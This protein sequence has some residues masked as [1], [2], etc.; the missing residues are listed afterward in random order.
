LRALAPEHGADVVE[1]LDAGT[2]VEPVFNIRP[3][4]AGSVLRTHGERRSVTI[5]EGVHFL[6]DNIGFRAYAARE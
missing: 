4:D 3:H 2:L 6:G 5:F 1:L